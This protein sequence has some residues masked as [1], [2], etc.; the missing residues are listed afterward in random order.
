M[1]NA[2]SAIELLP[3]APPLLLIDEVQQFNSKYIVI[4]KVFEIEDIFVKSH[5]VDRQER[6]VPGVLLIEMVGQAALLHQI[7]CGFRSGESQPAEIR[8]S[9]VLGRCKA[10]F[11]RPAKAGKILSVKVSTNGGALDA[12]HYSGTVSS[13]GI[14][15][16]KIEII[17][18]MDGNIK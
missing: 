2:T 7:I 10:S 4:N 3:Y 8:E 14:H 17:A 1:H 12:V 11:L 15:V 13:E 9:G 6:V 16:A 5:L 18:V